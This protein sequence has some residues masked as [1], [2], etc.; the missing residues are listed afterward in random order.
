M[1]D[2]V[3]SGEVSAA[4]LD[5]AVRKILRWKARL[6]LLRSRVVDVSRVASLVGAPENLA[7]AQQIADDGVALVRD[8]DGLL[9]LKTAPGAEGGLP[10][11]TS[12]E[13][14]N[15]LV[16]V[17]LSRDVRGLS[18]RIFGREVRRRVPDAN[19]VFLD[20]RTAAGAMD[21]VL[22]AAEEAEAVVVATFVAPEPGAAGAES[23]AGD[24][25]GQLL[26][27]LLEHVADKTVVAAVGSPYV[28]QAF[29]QI[30]SYLCTFSSVAVS[31]R[32]AVRALFGEIPTRGRLP[33][34]IPGV[35]AR[36]DGI[37]R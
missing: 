35:A 27:A 26:Q 8:G 37:T 22:R 3:K 15:R 6:G 14:R 36:G 25:A 4:R 7:V 12:V 2:A 32:S 9:P 17:V 30:R 28:A 13:T 10:Y 31:E 21:E 29:P 24:P 23:G 33:V 20:S 19:V 5:E 1:V 11:L 16:V 18:G 34:T